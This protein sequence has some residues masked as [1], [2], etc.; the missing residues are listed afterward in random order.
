MDRSD[1][2]RAFIAAATLGSSAQAAHIAV[3]DHPVHCGADA[4]ES[5]FGSFTEQ[6]ELYLESY[7]QV[8]EDTKPPGALQV[9]API[10][11]GRRHVLPIMT[12]L[13]IMHSGLAIRLTL[14]DRNAHRA[15]GAIDVA[16]RVGDL[17][18]SSMMA[19]RLGSVSRGLFADPDHLE[20]RNIPEA[21]NEF[22]AHDIIALER[23][24]TT[25][26]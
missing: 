25:N 12:R 5:D 17:V 14:P 13:S 3:R 19:I 21:P 10:M 15:E 4:F 18:D 8:L 22:T 26:E 24:D 20:R 1:S 2:M 6:S 7:R 9:A 23:L 16:V 11:F